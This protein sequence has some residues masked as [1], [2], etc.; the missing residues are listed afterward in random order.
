VVW[1]ILCNAGASLS[2]VDE[3]VIKPSVKQNNQ[4]L[5]T[6]SNFTPETDNVEFTMLQKRI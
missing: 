3:E 4:I 6:S 1:T 2:F 5:N